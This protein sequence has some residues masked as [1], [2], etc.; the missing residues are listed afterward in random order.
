VERKTKEQTID[1][2]IFLCRQIPRVHPRAFHTI[3][4]KKVAILLLSLT[5]TIGE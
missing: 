5:P 1:D 2:G 4:G 3:H